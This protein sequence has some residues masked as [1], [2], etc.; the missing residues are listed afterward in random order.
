MDGRVK[1]SND[2]CGLSFFLIRNRANVELMEYC[3]THPDGDPLTPYQHLLAEESI[4]TKL[5]DALVRCLE[6][7]K[8]RGD[9]ILIDRLSKWEIPKFPIS[10][11]MFLDRGLRGPVVGQAMNRLRYLWIVS[12]FQRTVE[13]LLQN[14][15]PVILK[16]ISEQKAAHSG[17]RKRKNSS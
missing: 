12:D 10:G 1:L 17:K 15:L 3:K 6:L 8:Y 5:S 4:S 7:L 9:S 16:D 14:A 2:E 11:T 13:D